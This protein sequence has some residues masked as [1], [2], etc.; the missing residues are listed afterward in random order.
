MNKATSPADRYCHNCHYP[1]AP[2]GD[3]CPHC[4]QKYTKG[5]VTVW[6]LIQDFLDSFFNFDSKLFLALRDLFYPGRLTTV[7][8]EGKHKRYVSPIRLFL[9]MAVLHFAVIGLLVQG[10]VEDALSSEIEEY[11]ENAHAADLLDSLQV[12]RK[13]VE[14]M[15]PGQKDIPIAIDSL[16]KQVKTSNDSMPVFLFLPSMVDSSS[17]RVESRIASKDVFSLTEEEVLDKYKFTGFWPRTQ[18]K[19]NLRAYKHLD[20]LATYVLSKL[21]WMVLL[22]MP[23]LSLILKLLYIRRKRYF[24]EHLV[25][26]FHFH[27]F[28]FLLMSAYYI[29]WANVAM[30]ETTTTLDI[31]IFAVVPVYLM[32]YL[33]LAM[34]RVY[35]Q[36]W[37]KTFIKMYILNVAY[38][39]IF[40]TFLI[41][42][43]VISAML[44]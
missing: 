23:A 2:Y 43:V 33:L 25:F 44:F 29:F 18:V 3:F 42:T 36:G 21:I 4:S 16:L 13:K 8:F 9:F 32:V 7:Y 5:K 31:I 27:A 19:Q 12:S 11:S 41:L 30:A 35:Q 28:A 39:I 37:I 14:Q 10:K 17:A 15:F 26:S 20:T 24:V 40:V 22:M 38:L 6:E 1:L 34:R